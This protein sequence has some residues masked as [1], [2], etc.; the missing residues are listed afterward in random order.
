MSNHELRSKNI[1]DVR[2]VSHER[3][4]AGYFHIDKYH[5]QYRLF[6]GGWSE[7][8]ARE[9]F[10]R[11]N[12]VAVLLYD[13]DRDK[14]VLIEQFRIGAIEDPKS[15]WLLEVIAGLIDD[16]ENLEEVAQRETEEESGLNIFALTPIYSYWVSPGGCSEHVYLFCGKVDASQAGGIH[17]LDGESEDI[18]VHV[19]TTQEAFD[20]VRNG[21]INNAATIIA[22]QW[23]ELNKDKI[24]T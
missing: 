7:I 8:V 18:K 20:L 12:A 5:A 10:R 2:I 23:L 17:G 24:F 21:T 15:P 3:A 1:D 6:E 13:P 14:V 11:G 22:L 19:F 4:Y 16:H 9:I